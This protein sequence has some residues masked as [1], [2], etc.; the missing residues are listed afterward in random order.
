MAT[1]IADHL[2]SRYVCTNATEPLADISS[3]KRMTAEQE[4]QALKSSG[5]QIPSSFFVSLEEEVEDL[6]E[7]CLMPSF[8]ECQ[9]PKKEHKAEGDFFFV[10]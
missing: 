8:S 4:Y 10:L 7:R 9:R 1:A 6:L 2:M 5:K 3:A